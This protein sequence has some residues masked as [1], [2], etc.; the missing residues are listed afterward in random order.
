MMQCKRRLTHLRARKSQEKLHYVLF[1]G[2]VIH[3]MASDII[4][5]IK[6]IHLIHLLV[7]VQMVQHVQKHLV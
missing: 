7:L 2:L 1:S 4:D 3:G 6:L 5:N